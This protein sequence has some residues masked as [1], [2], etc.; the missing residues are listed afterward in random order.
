[1]EAEKPTTRDTEPGLQLKQK[2]SQSLNSQQG[3]Q[4]DSGLCFQS[5]FLQTFAITLACFYD[6]L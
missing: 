4:P 2:K 5:G 6:V 1:M 3:D